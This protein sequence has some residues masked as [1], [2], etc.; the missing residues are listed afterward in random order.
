MKSTC[1]ATVNPETEELRAT[2]MALRE[3]EARFRVLAE[4][5]ADAFCLLDESSRIVE[6]NREAC[7]T[8]GYTRDELLEMFVFDLVPSL[9]VEAEQRMYA[10]LELGRPVTLEQ[11]QRRKDGTTFPVEVRL[12]A[13][14]FGGRRLFLRVAR[15]RSQREK[16][17]HALEQKHQQL[18]DVLDSMFIFV[19][20]FSKDG[21]ILEVN[22]APLEAAGL[23]RP[24][25]IGKIFWETVW[26]SHS[27]AAQ[28]RLQ[29]IFV[30][31]AQGEIVRR[32]EVIQTAK[33]GRMSVDMI[34][35]PLRDASGEITQIVGS[36]ADITE[37]QRMETDLRASRGELRAL[38]ADLRTVREEEAKRLSR[39][40]HDQ[41]G[42][43]LT[44]LQLDVTALREVVQRNRHDES[45]AVEARLEKMGQAI[46]DAIRTARRLASELRPA[47]LDDLG[48]SA[49][50]EWQT[51]E[52]EERAAIFCNL[53]LPAQDPAMSRDQAT[54]MFRIFQEVLT[55]VARHAQAT[56]VSVRFSA[57]AESTV[58][59]VS[60]NG[61]GMERPAEAHL[62][63]HGLLG[64]EERAIEAG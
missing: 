12:G 18:R 2:V 3:S 50:F 48:L 41:M 39:E 58:L 1:D 62:A 49:A 29:D 60:D 34:F 30:R 57:G 35:S 6:V 20:V 59:E 10:Q 38:A 24:E 47:V 13:I 43:A 25:V 37:R 42:Q 55:N 23:G 52:F 21:V 61:V 36:A 11:R 26:W 19:G 32:D 44:G 33:G 7:V 5:A 17:L 28:E 8:L 53:S 15:D 22:R 16:I 14:E 40:I 45:E 27:T 4:Q 56:E 51:R 31:V 54:A 9:T 63:G 64:M 46:E